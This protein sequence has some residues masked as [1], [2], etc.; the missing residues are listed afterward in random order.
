MPILIIFGIYVAPIVLMLTEI[1]PSGLKYYVLI[2]MSVLLLILSKLRGARLQDLGLT[3]KHLRRS[4]Q[5]LMPL[6]ALVAAVILALYFL[7][8]FR[9]DG[10]PAHWSF[11]IFYIFVSAFLQEFIYRGFLFH[12]LEQAKV[13]TRWII[14]ISAT[15]YGFMHVIFDIPS[16][17]FTF[18]IGIF[19]AWAYARDRNLYGVTASH[20]V[21]GSLSLL[22]NF[23]G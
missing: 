7:Q 3:R 19:W 4:L 1:V 10:E 15:L 11:Y 18:I 2:G 12:L 5:R 21:L 20:S 13:K 6:S 17:I 23:S 22:A 14:L 16:A 8:W 9:S